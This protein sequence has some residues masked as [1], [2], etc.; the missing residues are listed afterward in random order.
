MKNDI[1][2]TLTAH[3]IQKLQDDL[4]FGLYKPG[5]KIPPEP[6][7]MKIYNAG[8]STIREAV[9]T[10]ENIGI[11]TVKRG[12]GTF[13]NTQIERSV[14]DELKMKRYL[15]KEVNDVRYLLEKE[16]LIQALR[17]RTNE[18]IKN[19][20]EALDDRREATMRGR[21]E[22]SLDADIRF[23]VAIAQATHN[24]TLSEVYKHFTVQL[25]EYFRSRDRGNTSHFAMVHGLHSVLLQNIIRRS[26]E[27]GLNTLNKLLHNNYWR[28]GMPK[29]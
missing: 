15:L 14:T 26:E 18:D 1:S 20:S 5:E 9:K 17:Y 11:L 2:K 13:V 8:R 29:E 7:L 22:L 4:S 12:S 24:S 19:I 16:I 25:R 28:L 21:F 10:L 3:I 27:E 23:H 6:E